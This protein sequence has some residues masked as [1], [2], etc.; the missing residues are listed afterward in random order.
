[1]FV[2]KLVGSGAVYN[3]VSEIWAGLGVSRGGR[4]PQSRDAELLYYKTWIKVH[5][6][7]VLSQGRKLRSYD[8]NN[9]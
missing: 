9:L 2:V 4:G 8:N 7:N 1:L 6:Q 3:T 5:T